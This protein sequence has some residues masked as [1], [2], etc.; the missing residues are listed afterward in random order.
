MAIG[1]PPSTVPVAVARGLRRRATEAERELWR[2][3]RDRFRPGGHHFRRQVPIDAFVVDFACLKARLA[4]E[5]DGGGHATPHAAT[6]DLRRDARLR[7]L[8]FTV[9]RFW[10]QEVDREI[11]AVL[12][13]IAAALEGTGR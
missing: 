1:R 4:I 13:K 8:G 6:A 7:E 12:D 5:V 11:E 3:L 9:L 2:L 10:N